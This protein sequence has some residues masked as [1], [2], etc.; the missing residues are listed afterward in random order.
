VKNGIAQT[1]NLQAQL[2]IG[3]VGAVG[4]ANLVDSTL[5]LRVTAVLSQSA[6]QKVGGNSVGGF[7]QTALA[8]QQG[9]LVIPALV[10]GTFS[11]PRFAPDVQQI[12]QMKVKGLLPNLNNPGSVTG[13]LQNLLGG[14]MPAPGP[15]S[16]GQQQNP[17]QNTVDQVLGLFGKKKN[18]NQKPQ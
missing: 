18:Q 4:T 11:N 12:A 9:E 5:N 15:Q 2:D 6:S 3:N 8:N 16:Q 10:T 1:N 14:K 13:T 7:M 17:Q